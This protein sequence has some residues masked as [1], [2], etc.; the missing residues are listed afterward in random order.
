MKFKN[1]GFTLIELLAI[2]FILGILTVIIVTNVQ[3]VLIDSKNNTLI[4]SSKSLLKIFNEYYTKTKIKNNFYGCMYDF[5]SKQNTCDI[6]FNGRKPSAGRIYLDIEGNINGAFL[7]D[8]QLFEIC[9]GEICEEE[10][11]EKGKIY[12]FDYTGNEQILQIEQSGFYEVEVWGAQGGY[13]NN[14]NTG[15]YGG[16]SKGVIMLY[17][18]D[19]LYINVGGQGNNTGSDI[20]NGGYNGGGNAY[21]NSTYC[22]TTSGGGATHIAFKTGIL[23][24][25]K[26]DIDKIIIVGAGGAG[27]YNCR[28]LYNG[29]SAGGYIGGYNNKQEDAGNQNSGYAFGTGENKN[30][31]SEQI[32]RSGGGGGFYGG[33]SKSDGMAGG[34]SSYVGND[35]LTEKAMYCYNCTESN[36][37][38]TKTISV[39]NFSEEPTSQ[40]PKISNGYAKITFQGG[41]S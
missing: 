16:Y 7:F 35:L 25:L 8:N 20:I 28:Y 22:R 5:S 12:S 39:N 30:F 17:K 32:S 29:N 27:A 31:T 19:K 4:N 38:N 11:I 2:I 36:D 40:T 10:K 37:F 24:E 33:H 21:Y 26:N 41:L 3:K 18:G 1:K 13:L 6:E 9:N 34:G 23:S 15:G 14:L